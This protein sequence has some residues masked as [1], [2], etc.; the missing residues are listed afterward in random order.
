MRKAFKGQIQAGYI[1][2]VVNEKHKEWIDTR[3]THKGAN[4]YTKNKSDF[5]S[6][7]SEKNALNKPLSQ[8]EKEYVQAHE[9][10]IERD[11]RVMDLIYFWTGKNITEQAQAKS[12]TTKGASEDR[13]LLEASKEHMLKLSKQ[14]TNSTV[15][16]TI[17]S[18]RTLSTLANG[19]SDIL[20]EEQ[21]IR[22]RKKGMTSA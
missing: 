10:E 9:E 5:L 13:T 2:K 8:Q 17:N 7:E 20:Y 15:I 21:E 4:Q 6:T 16:W 18:L 22:E 19:F 1:W 3:K 14:M 12:N 11:Q